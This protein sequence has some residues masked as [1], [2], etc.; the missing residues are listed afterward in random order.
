MK[1]LVPEENPSGLEPAHLDNIPPSFA[2]S[3]SEVTKQLIS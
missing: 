2:Q 3:S 1:G